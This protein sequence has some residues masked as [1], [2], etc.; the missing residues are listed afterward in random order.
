MLGSLRPKPLLALKVLRAADSPH[1][2]ASAQEVG[3]T[4]IRRHRDN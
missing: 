3:T 1:A 2:A 4:G